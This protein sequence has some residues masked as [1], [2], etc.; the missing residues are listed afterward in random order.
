MRIRILWCLMLG[1]VFLVLNRTSFHLNA[2]RSLPERAFLVF[3]DLRP[4]K[5]DAVLIEN[6]TVKETT[7]PSL[8]KC[9]VGLPGDTVIHRDQTLY[10]NT[11]KVGGLLETTK[12]GDFLTLL[13]EQTIPEGFVFVAASH[14]DSF[15]SRYQEF[16][17]VPAHHLRGRAI[18]LF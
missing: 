17:L 4:Q 10:V 15:D 18:G 1:V 12:N 6:L 8:I 7:Y 11:T 2:S 9:L 14:P 16:G 3:N 5:G 13:S